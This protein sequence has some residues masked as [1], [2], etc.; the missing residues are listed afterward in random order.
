MMNDVP[1]PDDGRRGRIYVVAGAVFL[2]ALMVYLG[3]FI[4][5]QR[6]ARLE[7]AKTNAP[8]AAPAEPPARVAPEVPVVSEAEPEAPKAVRPRAPKTAPPPA[9]D[10]PLAPAGP[11]LRI[12]SDVAGAS[13][14]VDRVY[15][16]QTPVTTT[17][18]APG[19]HQLNVS[20]EGQEGIVR[21]IEVAAAEPTAVTVRFNEVVLDASVDV[22]HKHGVGSCDGRLTATVQGLRYETTN[23]GD[24]FSLPFDQVETFE[25]DYVGKNL[26]LKRRG[27][28]TWNFTSRA[29]NADPLFVFHR[30]VTKARQKLAATR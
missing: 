26:K 12:D 15:I 11:E 17:S 7:R 4:Q 5:A 22:V 28:K 10:A 2:L 20:A 19:S 16:G 3:F 8:V 1:T 21:T 13:V 24:A 29:A 25:I 18:V 27:G 30:D 23:K 9:P 6:R 14:F